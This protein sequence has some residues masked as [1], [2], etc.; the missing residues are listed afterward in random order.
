[1]CTSRAAELATPAARPDRPHGIGAPT[2]D[3]HALLEGAFRASDRAPN[4]TPDHEPDTGMDLG[5]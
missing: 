3:L 1:M 4:R 5:L 2:I